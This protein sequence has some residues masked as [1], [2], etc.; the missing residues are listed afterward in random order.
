MKKVIYLMLGI[1]NA[2][3]C[4]ISPIWLTMVFLNLTGLIYQYDGSMDEGTAFILGFVML[5][6]WGVY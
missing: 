4:F 5:V 2:I 3:A 6:L 1:W